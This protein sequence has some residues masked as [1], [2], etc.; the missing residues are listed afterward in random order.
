VLSLSA[1]DTTSRRASGFELQVILVGVVNHDDSA[2]APFA[3]KARTI[4]AERNEGSAPPPAS[5]SRVCLWSA[6]ESRFG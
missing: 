5:C 3:A 2:K 4:S 6:N 1:L